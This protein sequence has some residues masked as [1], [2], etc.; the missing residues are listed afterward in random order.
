MA[1]YTR[2]CCPGEQQL[3]LQCLVAAATEIISADFSFSCAYMTLL[4]RR[5]CVVCRVVTFVNRIH[6][7]LML[8]TEHLGSVLLCTQ[9]VF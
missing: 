7:E 6:F 3:P 4:T 2:T 9:L 5:A 8:A 1:Q